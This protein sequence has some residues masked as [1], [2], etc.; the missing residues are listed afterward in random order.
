MIAELVIIRP[1]PVLQYL[2]H[3]LKK[4]HQL[5]SSCHFL[6]E[7]AGYATQHRLDIIR[8]FHLLVQVVCDALQHV[9]DLLTAH[10]LK[11]FA[12]LLLPGLL[13]LRNSVIR[14]CH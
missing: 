6:I 1:I 13:F 9:H 14:V 12:Q 2:V 3:G 8:H 7:G 11:T 10:L 4:I 5:R